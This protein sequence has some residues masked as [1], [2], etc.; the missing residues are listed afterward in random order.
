MPGDAP[1]RS[2][3]RAAPQDRG[4]VRRQLLREAAVA[5]L[6]DTPLSALTL[7]A[8]AERAGIPKASAYHFYTSILDLYSELVAHFG[9]LLAETIV[10]PDDSRF[11]DWRSLVEQVLVAGVDLLNESTV[12]RKLVLSPDV[13]PSVKLGDRRN[14]LR[15]GSILRQQVERHF[16]LPERYDFDLRFYYAIEIVDFMCGLSVA[17]HGVVTP[18]MR[19]ESARAGC[20]YLGLYLPAD[21]PQATG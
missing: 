6:E 14:D 20:A 17:E 3:R 8:V 7:T 13:P 2:R 10:V 21:L 11:P 4:L 19:S 12:G 9:E 5:C 18:E 15:L 1:A 16:C